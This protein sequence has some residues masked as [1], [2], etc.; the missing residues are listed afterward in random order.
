MLRVRARCFD[1]ATSQFYLY[2]SNLE[3]SHLKVFLMSKLCHC[4]FRKQ[5]KDYITLQGNGLIVKDE[6]A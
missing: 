6:K 2:C 5:D 3:M 1:L 4:S